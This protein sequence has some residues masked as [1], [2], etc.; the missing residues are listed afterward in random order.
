MPLSK[1]ALCVVIA[2]A[3]ARLANAQTEIRLWPEGAPGSNGPSHPESVA[4]SPSGDRVITNVSDPT[5]TAFLPDAAGATGA[6]VVIAHGSALR[7]APRAQAHQPGVGQS[8]MMPQ[9]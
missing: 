5:L 2:L 4:R 9:L 8:K 6:A 3:A 1:V 7:M